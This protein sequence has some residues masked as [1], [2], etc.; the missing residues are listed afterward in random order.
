MSSGQ[1]WS[2]LSIYHWS[3]FII[4]HLNIYH[5][6][7]FIIDQHYYWPALVIDQHLPL[8]RIYHWSAFIIDHHL[9]SIKSPHWSTLTSI[10]HYLAPLTTIYQQSALTIIYNRWPPLIIINWLRA[11][12]GPELVIVSL[13]L[14]EE[15][16]RQRLTERHPDQDS[17]VKYLMVTSLTSF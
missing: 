4:Q 10:D 6:L 2:L 5:W 12:L 8:I 17:V 14:E 11:A 16:V 9:L 3:A 1:H 7:A 15:G 13:V